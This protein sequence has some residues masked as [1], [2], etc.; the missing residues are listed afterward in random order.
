LDSDAINAFFLP[1]QASIV[2]GFHV[3]EIKFLPEAPY[4]PQVLSKPLRP[5]VCIARESATGKF[6]RCV[7]LVI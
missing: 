7:G 4:H 3:F 5:A 1:K 2:V 6:E